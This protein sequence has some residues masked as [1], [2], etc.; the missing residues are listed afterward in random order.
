MAR[1]GER[2]KG[3]GRHHRDAFERHER[4]HPPGVWDDPAAKLTCV[5]LSVTLYIG[6]CRVVIFVLASINAGHAALLNIDR[7]RH[8]LGA[9]RGGGLLHAIS[10]ASWE[11][12]PSFAQGNGAA[13]LVPRQAQ[14]FLN[15]S[16]YRTLGATY[17]Y[18][19]CVV[20]DNYLFVHGRG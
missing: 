14:G 12:A 15:V 16:S 20:C 9:A 13:A 4:V 10:R 17:S 2:W 19:S 6:T 5:W 3:R 7:D 11:A 18:H 8:D 1:M